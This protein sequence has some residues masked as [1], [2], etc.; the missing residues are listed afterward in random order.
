MKRRELEWEIPKQGEQHAQKAWG[1]KWLVPFGIEQ[2]LWQ[3][4]CEKASGP[5]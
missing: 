2:G 1:G 3:R 4:E 5:R